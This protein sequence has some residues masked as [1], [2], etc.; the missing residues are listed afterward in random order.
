MSPR[1][2]RNVLREIRPVPLGQTFRLGGLDPLTVPGVDYKFLRFGLGARVWVTPA[3][4]VDGGAAFDAVSDLGKGTGDIA[5]PAFLPQA[6]GY[7]VDLGVSIGVRLAGPFGLRFGGDFRQY[8]ISGNSHTTDPVRVGGAADRY[9]T[10]WGGLELIFDGL[11][12][13]AETQS[14]EEGKPAAK[15]AA[16]RRQAEPDLDDQ[17]S[18]QSGK[19]DSNEDGEQDNE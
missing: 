7:G 1:V 5:S 2:V 17:D 12:G 15:K 3:I 8:G 13:A 11:G 16:R 6:S 14:E 4:D 10:G 18:D 19:K 9:V